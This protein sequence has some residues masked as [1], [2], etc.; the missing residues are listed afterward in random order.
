M[1]AIRGFGKEWHRHESGGFAEFDS[2]ILYDV[3]EFENVITALN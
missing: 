1:H 2:R 3:F